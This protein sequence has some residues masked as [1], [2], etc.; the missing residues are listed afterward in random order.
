[1]TMK[2]TEKKTEEKKVSIKGIISKKLKKAAIADLAVDV[3]C[4]PVGAYRHLKRSMG[5]AKT[6]ET[7]ET[8]IDTVLGENTLEDL[9]KLGEDFIPATAPAET[10]TEE[11][12]VN[13]EKEEKEEA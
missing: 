5:I 7:A 9:V 4:P 10:E 8:A 2:K 1:M 11:T 3:L 12:E 6:V 13:E